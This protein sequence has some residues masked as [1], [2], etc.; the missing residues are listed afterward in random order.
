MGKTTSKKSL[1]KASAGK[2]PP[3]D[4]TLGIEPAINFYTLEDVDYTAEGEEAEI[5]FVHNSSLAASKKN[6]V[7]RKFPY[8]DTFNHA[9]PAVVNVMRD[10]TRGVF[11]HL[12]ITSPMD[13]DK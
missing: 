7:T 9:G 6:R 12:D 3:G 11:K 5:L 1:V 8:I 2:P 4:K 13:M 10:L